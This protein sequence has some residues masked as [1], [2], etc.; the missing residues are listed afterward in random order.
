MISP[1]VELR[2][3]TIS[4]GALTV[5]NDCS[6]TV[7]PGEF[8]TLVGPSGCGKSTLLNLIAG[9]LGG[10]TVSCAE[11]RVEAVRIG[12]A[13]QDELLLPWKTVRDNIQLPLEL[14]G[15]MPDAG[16]LAQLLT[17]ARLTGFESY[18]PY[19]LSGGMKKRVTLLS[20][21]AVKPDLLLL[22]EPFAN[23][24]AYTKLRLQ[25]FFL[26]LLAVHRTTT[27]LVTHDLD[28]AVLFSTRVLVL[29]DKPAQILD[30]VLIDVPWP[31]DP[32]AERSGLENYKTRILQ[33][34]LT[35]SAIE[36]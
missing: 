19:Q 10:A 6:L 11:R 22:D 9:V 26:D 2:R 21:L 25:K 32:F 3:C 30:D 35:E 33:Q 13:T 14:L 29:A 1:K 17:V 36:A 20:A 4:Y 7:Q 12:Y 28:E 34:L 18:R 24:D 16:F 31:R 23:I 5:V 8:V 27:V 15:E